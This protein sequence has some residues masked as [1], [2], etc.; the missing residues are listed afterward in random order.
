MKIKTFKSYY[1]LEYI[2]ITVPVKSTKHG[3]VIIVDPGMIEKA[4]A[5]IILENQVAIRGL[6]AKLLRKFMGLSLERFGGELG[7]SGS[8]ILKWEKEPRKRIGIPNEVAVR[9]FAAER[10]GIAIPG[11]L[12]SLKGNP[13]LPDEP[14]AVNLT[15]T[16]SR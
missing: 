7:M 2:S 8:A 9:V 6:E 16:A 3:D 15:K 5:E 13:V 12:S 4:V 1:G 11:K 10:L 14:Y